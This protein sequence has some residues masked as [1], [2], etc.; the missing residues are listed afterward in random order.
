MEAAKSSETSVSYHHYTASEPR[1]SRMT[2]IF[3]LSENLKYLLFAA[4]KLSYSKP[5]DHFLVLNKTRFAH[6]PHQVYVIQDIK[7]LDEVCCRVWN[8]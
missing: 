6:S 7:H 5:H 4:Y 2:S 1:R 8:N 3:K